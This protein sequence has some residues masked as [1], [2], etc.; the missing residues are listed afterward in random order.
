MRIT[1]ASAVTISDDTTRELGIV[2]VPLGNSYATPVTKFADVSSPGAT[3]DVAASGN[4]AAGSYEVSWMVTCN[5]STPNL[6]IAHLDASDAD[7]AT[8]RYEIPT[9]GTHAGTFH[10]DI[11]ADEELRIRTIGAVTGSVGVVLSLRRLL[12]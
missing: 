10:M 6:E 8:A 12:V 5:N 11:G 9:S 7:V 1:S 4:L 3:T 2:S